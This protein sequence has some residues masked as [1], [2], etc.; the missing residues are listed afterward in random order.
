MQEEPGS[1]LRNM[2]LHLSKQLLN[3]LFS[4]ERNNHFQNYISIDNNMDFY[5]YSFYEKKIRSN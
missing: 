2:E 1:L 4:I 5:D 3:T